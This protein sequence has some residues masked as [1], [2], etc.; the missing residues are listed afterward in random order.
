MIN[1]CGLLS[2]NGCENSVGG[3]IDEGDSNTC[4]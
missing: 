2:I 1:A 4:S 3:G